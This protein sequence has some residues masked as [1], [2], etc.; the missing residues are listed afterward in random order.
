MSLELYGG[1]WV[2]EVEGSEVYSVTVEISDSGG[3]MDAFCD[4]PYDLAMLAH[5]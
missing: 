5:L 2:A 4:C 3:I 1:E